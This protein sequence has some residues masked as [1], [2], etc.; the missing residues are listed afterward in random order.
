SPHPDPLT[1]TGHFLS[2]AG[3]GEV[4]IAT[5]VV[6]PGRTSTTLA[7]ALIQD[8]RERIRMAAT[9]G[10]LDDRQGPNHLY[11]EPPKI[12]PPYETRR[13]MLVQNFPDNF[14]LRL[15]ASVAGGAMGEPTGEPEIGG[16][17]EF[18]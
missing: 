8:G 1:V 18:A 14:N 5:E 13:S 10:D 6:K 17:I 3:T 9:F 7:A 15:P 2:P 11:L 12:Q 4:Q 16:T